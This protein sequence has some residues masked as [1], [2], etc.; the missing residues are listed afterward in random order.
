MADI[1]QHHSSITLQQALQ[2][3]P[4]ESPDASVWPMLLQQLPAKKKRTYLPTALAASLALFAVLPLAFNTPNVA[5]PAME[6]GIPSLIKTSAQL[7]TI[8]GATRNSTSSNAS[9]ELMSLA[10][11]EQLQAID[12][13][14][15]NTSLSGVQQT[16]LWKKRVSV[17]QEAT[18]FYA[19]QRYQQSEGKMFD[20]AFVESY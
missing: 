14:L 18:Q 13:Q 1:S 11:E 8:L 4:L 2:N 6:P 5:P 15:S 19:S 17:L 12:F 9:A 3:L 7:E 10:W 20:I 16:A